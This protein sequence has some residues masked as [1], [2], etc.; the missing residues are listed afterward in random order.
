MVRDLALEARIVAKFA[1][2]GPLL[3]ER[4]RRLWAATE[5]LAIGFG[6]DAV[7][8]A[9]T[10]LARE[11]IRNGRREIANGLDAT[12]RVRRPGAGRPPIETTQPGLKRALEQLV[13]PL[14][15]GD[16]MSPLR[17]TCKSKEP[18]G[19]CLARSGSC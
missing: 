13:E 19:I 2:I 11:T 9:A 3:N 18:S 14:T 5:S 16:P 10:G 8:S 1:T 6:G 17:W 12:I 4:S 7:V 15:R